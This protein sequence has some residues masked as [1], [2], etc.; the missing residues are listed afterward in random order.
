MGYSKPDA[1]VPFCQIGFCYKV[2]WEAEIPSEGMIQDVEWKK[3]EAFGQLHRTS[4]SYSSEAKV[5]SFR[6]PA[7]I[8]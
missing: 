2:P 8:I 5:T 6:F 4:V 7:L 1:D 3:G